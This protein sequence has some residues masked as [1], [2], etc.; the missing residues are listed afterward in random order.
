NQTEVALRLPGA[1]DIACRG[2]KITWCL[3]IRGN[4]MNQADSEKEAAVGEVLMRLGKAFAA[5]DVSGL[6]AVYAEDADWVNAFGSHCQ[7]RDEIMAYLKT[8]FAD[9]RFGAGRMM[10]SPEASIR[11]ID[12]GR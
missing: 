5:C 10:G 7:G 8:L 1:C 9:A 11:F 4:N 6:E 2:W 3:T 12:D